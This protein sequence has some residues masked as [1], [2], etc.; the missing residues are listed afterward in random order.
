M[1]PKK[2]NN[3]DEPRR[4]PL[5]AYNSFPRID[6]VSAD[7]TRR[8]RAS[9]ADGYNPNLSTEDSASNNENGK[10]DSE[11]DSIPSATERARA[12]NDKSGDVD[13]TE[14]PSDFD[15]LPVELIS[16]TDT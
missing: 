10:P 9:T 16:L 3:G 11:S 14:L 12:A 15:E 8:N 5:Q 1:A 6:P 7:S 13:T 2:Q 4:R